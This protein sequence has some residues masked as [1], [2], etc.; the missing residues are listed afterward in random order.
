LT[1]C[2]EPDGLVSCFF[3]RADDDLRGH[4]LGFLGESLVRFDEENPDAILAR[5]KALWKHRLNVAELGQVASESTGFSREIG[6]FGW[7]FVSG[8][9][10]DRWAVDQLTQALEHGGELRN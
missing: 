7:W 10:D 5:L 4:A 8:K 6:A 9:F 2:A 1:L 3:D